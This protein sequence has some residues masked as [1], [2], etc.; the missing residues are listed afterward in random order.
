VNYIQNNPFW[1]MVGLSLVVHGSVFGF[2][3]GDGQIESPVIQESTLRISLIEEVA[4]TPASPQQREETKEIIEEPVV[5]QEIIK[6]VREPEP[7]P[8][9]PLVEK[10]LNQK[11][12]EKPPV[13]RQPVQSAPAVTSTSEVSP[14]L[15]A[16]YEQLIVSH[17]ERHKE[18]PRRAVRRNLEG[19]AM[20]YLRVAPDGSLKFSQLQSS[21]GVS[22]LDEEIVA[23][24]RRANPFPKAPQGIHREIEL[25]IP[26][27]FELK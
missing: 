26:I 17:L 8:V 11:I 18:Y 2:L 14:K 20:L 19:Q 12:I 6:P 13:E 1:I 5:E 27:A 25:S 22:I 21:T 3:S 7:K 9:Q 10:A 16:S 24:V 23:M 4:E 15:Q